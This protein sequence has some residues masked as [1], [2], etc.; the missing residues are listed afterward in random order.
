MKHKVAQH[1]ITMGRALNSHPSSM[2][3]PLNSNSPS[4]GE[5]LE[6]AND[7][8][9]LYM[10]STADTTDPV[11]KLITGVNMVRDRMVERSTS[12][13]QQ[14]P[15]GSGRQAS[16]KFSSGCGGAF[17]Y[18]GSNV[19]A[20]NRPDHRKYPQLDTRTYE[21]RNCSGCHKSSRSLHPGNR[22]FW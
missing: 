6:R 2:K 11:D 17:L 1:G 13:Y 14:Q 3:R 12:H 22:Y 5:C 18:S 9:S 8:I 10:I 20:D 19:G 7:N 21:V 16:R 4:L 15:Q